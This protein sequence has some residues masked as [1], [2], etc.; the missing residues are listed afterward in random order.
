MRWLLEPS[1]EL[2]AQSVEIQQIESRFFNLQ[3]VS[4]LLTTD[5][6]LLPG[7]ASRHDV[8]HGQL[9]AVGQLQT[10]AEDARC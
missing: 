8:Q 10:V 2:G 1:G 6:G 5:A 9:A 4:L 3:S 7:L